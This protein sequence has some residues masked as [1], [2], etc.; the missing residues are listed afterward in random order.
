MSF[1]LRF[2]LQW[3]RTVVST[4]FDKCFTN[5]FLKNSFYFKPQGFLHIIYKSSK[6]FSIKKVLKQKKITMGKNQEKK[7]KI[8]TYPQSLLDT[9]HNKHNMSNTC[10]WR[11]RGKYFECKEFTLNNN[12]YTGWTDL[13]KHKTDLL[14][15]TIK[16]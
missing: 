1:L 16:T 4:A 7:W 10:I 11:I 8:V 3:H 12:E 15:W 14:K 9:A 5:L 2:Y 6:Q 13:T